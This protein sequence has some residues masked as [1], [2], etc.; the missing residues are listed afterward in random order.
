MSSPLLNS[1]IRG[2]GDGRG[3]GGTVQGNAVQCKGFSVV[4]IFSGVG[5]ILQ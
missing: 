2:G 4:G 5:Y 1:V 3:Q